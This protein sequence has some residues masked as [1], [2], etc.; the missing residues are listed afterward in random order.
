M[1]HTKIGN[2]VDKETSSGLPGWPYRSSYNHI[3][4]ALAGLPKLY[5]SPL[6]GKVVVEICVRNWLDVWVHEAQNF[7]NGFFEFKSAPNWMFTINLTYMQEFG[8]LQS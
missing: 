2:L 5:S 7:F 3:V 6:I 4:Y 8:G 1:Y